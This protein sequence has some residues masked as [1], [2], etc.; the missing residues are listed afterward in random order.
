MKTFTLIGLAAS[1]LGC[2]GLYLA[3]PNQ[4]LLAAQWPARPA[5]VAGTALLAAGWLGLAQDMQTLTAS[6]T[7]V[8]V[9]MLAFALLPYVG[10]L[11]GRG[12]GR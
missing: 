12:K 1:L 2:A 9:L 7:F 10:A 5:R 8:V 11:C 4:R 3:S 6:F